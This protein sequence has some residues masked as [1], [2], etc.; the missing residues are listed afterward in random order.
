MGSMASI[1]PAENI[2]VPNTEEKDLTPTRGTQSVNWATAL[3]CCF[4]SARP[5]QGGGWNVRGRL[6]ALHSSA[7]GLFSWPRRWPST[8]RLHKPPYV[9][10]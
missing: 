9:E 8:K 1:N 2:R 10:K 7:G 5:A 4:G 6:P 3:G